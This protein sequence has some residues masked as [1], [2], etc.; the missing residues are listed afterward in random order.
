MHLHGE[1]SMIETIMIDYY[2][3]ILQ[4][5][6]LSLILFVLALNTL[7]HLLSKEEQAN[8]RRSD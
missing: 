5:D 2:R 1:T 6:L 3:G 7:S 4:G 8:K